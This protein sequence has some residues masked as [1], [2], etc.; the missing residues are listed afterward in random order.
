VVT[1]KG[2]TLERLLLDF[3]QSTARKGLVDT[4]LAPTVEASTKEE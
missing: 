1:G 4:H 3:G 2:Q